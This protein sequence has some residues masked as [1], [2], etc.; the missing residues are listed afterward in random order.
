MCICIFDKASSTREVDVDGMLFKSSI[1]CTLVKKSFRV[2]ALSFGVNAIEPSALVR[3]GIDCLVFSLVL[4]YFHIRGGI[5]NR[6]SFFNGIVPLR[7]GGGGGKDYKYVKKNENLP[8][9]LL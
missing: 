6:F 2:S 5:D 1:M 3:D 4:A 8:K 9:G 7:R